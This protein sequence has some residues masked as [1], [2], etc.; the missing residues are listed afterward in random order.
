MRLI[1][2]VDGKMSIAERTIPC[3]LGRAGVV[4]ASAKIEG[5]GASPAGVWPL[6]RVYFRPDRVERPITRLPV[7]PLKLSDGW[8]DDPTDPNY[9]R[10]VRL[11]YEASAE[12]LWRD[13]G[14]YDLIVVLGY[15]DEP[16]S[17]G[18]GSAI[19]LHL[20]K[21]D[22]EPTQGCVAVAREDLTALLA[23][24]GPDDTLSIS[25]ESAP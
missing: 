3:A 5:D 2:Y 9:N 23:L 20:A 17:P 1:A 12:R 19:F 24:A 10:W 22:Y 16:V 21:D 7:S 15:N 8:C 25:L 18:G 4:P 6:R 13:D 11:P 14:L